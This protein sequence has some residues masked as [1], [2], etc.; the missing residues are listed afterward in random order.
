MSA[1]L[2]PEVA[3]VVIALALERSIANGTTVEE[4][5]EQVLAVVREMHEEQQEDSPQEDP[6]EPA[7]APAQAP[8]EAKAL[9]S[10]NPLLGGALVG[11]PALPKS[12]LRKQS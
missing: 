10:V 9:S 2:D 6:A 5:M 4:E 12:R 1:Q 3:E 7:E 11:A 8:P